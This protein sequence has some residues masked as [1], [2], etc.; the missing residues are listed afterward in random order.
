M[1]VVVGSLNQAKSAAVSEAFG[2]VFQDELVSLHL[3][4]VPSG[5]RDQPLSSEECI[6][7][8]ENRARLA[9]MKTPRADF[10]V[11]L[12]AGLQ[13]IGDYWF[14]LAWAAVLSRKGILGLGCS[15]GMLVPSP[16]FERILGGESLGQVTD[17]L[18]QVQDC[19][20]G[21]G[22]FG[23]MTNGLI[24][25]AKAYEDAVIFAL[26]RFIHPEIF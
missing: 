26:T 21:Q 1:F 18:F 3:L 19:G 23:L 25:R 24:T 14:D 11:G 4:G 2:K 5:V 20:Q 12:E 17:E 9:M 16:I 15:A 8:A 6:E 13:K 10:A 22:Y 7:G